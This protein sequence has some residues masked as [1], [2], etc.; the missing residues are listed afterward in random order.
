MS[1]VSTRHQRDWARALA[2][3]NVMAETMDLGYLYTKANWRRDGAFVDE[4]DR[5]LAGEAL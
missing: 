5:L 3:G 2:I 1:P 4:L